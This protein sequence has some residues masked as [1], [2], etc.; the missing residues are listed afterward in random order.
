MARHLLDLVLTGIREA[1]TSDPSDGFDY[2]DETEVMVLKE[3]WNMID[4]FSRVEA[5]GEK[6]IKCR[7]QTGW[8]TTGEA[9]VA[10]KLSGLYIVPNEGTAEANEW[11]DRIWQP[12]GVHAK[13]RKSDVYELED[14]AH[15]KAVPCHLGDI[16]RD[17]KGAVAIGWPEFLAIV[18]ALQ[19]PAKCRGGKVGL[20][21]IDVSR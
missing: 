20:A 4:V 7:E 3:A 18:G 16:D 8:I 21:R 11:E 13:S 10:L 1:N 14:E 5:A 17:M 19:N 6:S 2:L 9:L 12:R 15:D